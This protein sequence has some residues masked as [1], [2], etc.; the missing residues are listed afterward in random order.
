MGNDLLK[1]AHKRRRRAMYIVEKKLP[2]LG[3]KLSEFLTSQLPAI[4]NGDQSI[5]AF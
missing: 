5:P 1:E 4:D 2:K 3:E